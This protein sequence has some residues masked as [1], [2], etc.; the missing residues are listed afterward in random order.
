MA[1]ACQAADG[2]AYP[3]PLNLRLCEKSLFGCL[4]S[5]PINRCPLHKSRPGGYNGHQKYLKEYGLNVSK[6]Q[7]AAFVKELNRYRRRHPEW[8]LVEAETADGDYVKVKL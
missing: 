4:V 8:V 3:S 6:A 1:D 7:A 5:G 2:N